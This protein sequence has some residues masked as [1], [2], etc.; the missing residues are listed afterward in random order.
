MRT[1]ISLVT[2]LDA[3]WSS[4]V[5]ARNAATYVAN[6]TDM[7]NKFSGCTRAVI[8]YVNE[9]VNHRMGSNMVLLL[10]VAA[11]DVYNWL[12]SMQ[13]I[14]VSELF[15]SVSNS[16]GEYSCRIFSHIKSVL[17]SYISSTVTSNSD[18][19]QEDAW[20][21]SVVF[22]TTIISKSP[23]GRTLTELQAFGIPITS[24][25]RNL[26]HFSLNYSTSLYPNTGDI[27]NTVFTFMKAAL[28]IAPASL[29][30]EISGILVGAVDAQVQHFQQIQSDD[31]NSYSLVKR[32]QLLL[33]LALALRPG[34][35]ATSVIHSE[36]LNVIFHL[37]RVSA[38]EMKLI[39]KS[40]TTAELLSLLFAGDL[41]F[42]SSGLSLSQ[43]TLVFSD[44]AAAK[45]PSL[46][47]VIAHPK[48][49]SKLYQQYSRLI[50]D[51]VVTAPSSSPVSLYHSD[52]LLHILSSSQHEPSRILL[53]DILSYI[54][55][56]IACNPELVNYVVYTMVPLLE[57]RVNLT[58]LSSS[59][60]L[61]LATILAQVTAITSRLCECRALRTYMLH[62]LMLTFDNP[63]DVTKVVQCLSWLPLLL[64]GCTTSSSRSLSLV[65]MQGEAAELARV[66]EGLENLVSTRFPLDS[67]QLPVSSS[68]G[69]EFL[70]ILEAYLQ[71]FQACGSVIMLPPLYPALR[72]G[73]QHIYYQSFIKVISSV[74]KSLPSL[75]PT[76]TMEHSGS[77]HLYTE[78][79]HICNFCLEVIYNVYQDVP[80]K[81]ILLEFLLLPTLLSLSSKNMVV[82]FSL[83]YH[84]GLQIR[85][86]S[87]SSDHS[88]IKV[89]HDIIAGDIFPANMS[90][91][92]LLSHVYMV[93]VAY[94]MLSL[95][96]DHCYV[97]DVKLTLTAA[98][99]HGDMSNTVNIKGSELTSAVLKVAHKFVRT[100]M[101][102]IPNYYAYSIVSELKE[103]LFELYAA[104][105]SCLV[106]IVCKTQS[107]EKFYD[108]FIFSQKPSEDIYD[109]ILHYPPLDVENDASL[110]STFTRK[111]DDARLS[112][113][114]YSQSDW[115]MRNREVNAVVTVQRLCTQAK[116]RLGKGGYA[117]Q[118]LQ[119]CMLSSSQAVQSVAAPLQTSSIKPPS[120]T[121]VEGDYTL[122]QYDYTNMLGNGGGSSATDYRI[123][124]PNSAAVVAGWDDQQ[125][126]LE[127][128]HFNSIHIM[129]TLVRA[130]QRMYVL[131]K[132]KW[133]ANTATLPN[134]LKECYELVLSSKHKKAKMFILRL[135]IN[136]PVATIIKPWL[137]LMLPGVLENIYSIYCHN[138]KGYHYLL[139]DVMFTFWD[140]WA[141]VTIPVASLKHAGM[142]L[143]FLLTHLDH[144]D[145]DVLK[146]NLN[147][148]CSIFPRWLQLYSTSQQKTRIYNIALPYVPL[149]VDAIIRLLNTAYTMTGGA[150]GSIYSTGS[151]AVRYRLAALDVVH[152]LLDCNYPLLVDYTLVNNVLSNFGNPN[153]NITTQALLQ[154]ILDNLSISRKE[155]VQSSCQVIGQILDLLNAHSMQA[156]QVLL[157]SQLGEFENKVV[158][159]IDGKDKA[160]RGKETVVYC[161][162]C[163]LANY[164]GFLKREMICR[165]L[166]WFN[167]FTFQGRYS[168]LEMLLRHNSIFVKSGTDC[169]H[170]MILEL[171]R[172]FIKPM[173]VDRNVTA[174]GRGAGMVKIPLLQVYALILLTKHIQHI[175]NTSEG[176]QDP[177]TKQHN[178]TVL[179]EVLISI[180]GKD[181][182]V[183]V[184]Y[185]INAN[186][187]VSV[188]YAA[189]NLLI[190]I[191]IYR[192]K[193]LAGSSSKDVLQS[194]VQLL[195]NGLNDPDGDIYSKTDVAGQLPKD[196]NILD[197]ISNDSIQK[198]I[199]P[200]YWS[201]RSP[202][203]QI[204]QL[205][206][207]FFQGYYLIN[208]V[209]IGQ[210]LHGYIILLCKELFDIKSVNNWL[211]Y[212]PSLL[213]SVILQHPK[214]LEVLFNISLL[215]NVTPTYQPLSTRSS[216][217]TSSAGFSSSTPLFALERTSQSIQMLALQ[218]PSIAK[219]FAGCL[220]QGLQ[221][222]I[223]GTSY[224]GEDR[225]MKYV[226]GTQQISW[227]QNS[228]SFD[229]STLNYS[230]HKF[231]EPTGTTK[232]VS[233]AASSSVAPL[234]SFPFQT[235]VGGGGISQPGTFSMGP[236]TSL[237]R[238]M[239]TQ[240]LPVR[241]SAHSMQQA[242]SSI[243]NKMIYRRT[244]TAEEAQNKHMSDVYNVDLHA[245]YRVGE[246]PD[247]A[248][249]AAN[250]I[251][252]L[253]T[254]CLY[255]PAA[256]SQL[257]CL[258]LVSQYRSVD[259]VK[260]GIELIDCLCDILKQ[261]QSCSPTCILI[262]TIL[263]VFIEL[264]SCQPEFVKVL[265]AKL[266]DATVCQIALSCGC[267]H[268]GIRYLEAKLNIIKNSTF[269]AGK[270][271]SAV[272][273]DTAK[274]TGHSAKRRKGASSSAGIGN[275][276]DTID[277]LFAQIETS[278]G[279]PA[280][281]KNTVVTFDDVD[282][283]SIFIQ[284]MHLYD[285]LSE[286]NIVNTLA[287]A[288]FLNDRSSDEAAAQMKEAI[289]YE[290]R[291]EF[292][293]AVEVYNSLLRGIGSNSGSQLTGPCKKRNFA[294]SQ[295]D[296]SSLG[297]GQVLG[298]LVGRSL[299]CYH[300]LASWESLY[301]CT[302]YLFEGSGVVDRMDLDGES[303]QR[304]LSDFVLNQSLADEDRAAHLRRTAASYY[305]RSFIHLSFP[306]LEKPLAMQSRAFLATQLIA[307]KS[308]HS[309]SLSSLDLAAS[310]IL[311]ED[312]YQASLAMKDAVS[313][314]LNK[315]TMLHAVAYKGKAGLLLSLQRMNELRDFIF[316][317]TQQ[318][319]IAS[320]ISAMQGLANSTGQQKKIALNNLEDDIIKAWTLS[321]PNIFD[322]LHHWSDVIWTRSLM[323]QKLADSNSNQDAQLSAK[324]AEHIS[325]MFLR[326]AVAAVAQG[327]LTAVKPLLETAN[328]V[329]KGMRV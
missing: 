233:G 154:A 297:Q 12:V 133:I 70:V 5:V 167:S 155:L 157:Y 113:N 243:I 318:A 143:N 309:A 314:F 91:E 35:V 251:K 244:M 153:T 323:L 271:L 94:K 208:C 92:T 119:S 14:Q 277:E 65:D 320:K 90:D 188:R 42:Y 43:E 227:T 180:I 253:Q 250:L 219:K 321:E 99:V 177:E 148:V 34:V 206:Y 187:H 20:I 274:S 146:E 231:A 96:Y 152:C 9:H 85:M 61:Q 182:T 110:F 135:F 234:S 97:G 22:L 267:F 112:N 81:R 224:T 241:F 132:E 24:L 54:S 230:Y 201:K 247:I 299:E 38:D 317:N 125:V 258:L 226:K 134:W 86:S 225:N 195:L 79:K 15:D 17:D 120:M 137:H 285:R 4:N 29:C 325:G 44:S 302:A 301:S 55:D 191:F 207:E 3:D 270:A 139:R 64:P 284:L 144:D 279:D 80:I 78:V 114:I 282:S 131:F 7:L 166:L 46:L 6:W 121:R 45:N 255:N 237:P 210:G 72:E 179:Q 205:I 174:I 28:E 328:A 263:Q 127:M 168:Y 264:S 136:Q 56:Q 140:T 245:E 67:S 200:A 88:I 33:K 19:R 21:R 82:L 213:L 118:Y 59:A 141:D 286:E 171:V 1:F 223:F 202:R 18:W 151:I 289:D 265:H 305:L 257:L 196:S 311:L 209:N 57:S 138:K 87:V 122:S 292:T 327:K 75:P 221:T 48:Y 322:P 150:H 287:E 51:A 10:F 290:A 123:A 58:T 197:S 278:T 220:S 268:I 183:A 259:L 106:T 246:A 236:P 298:L 108:N 11:L 222:S 239:T 117:S 160:K 283:S 217:L 178:E 53:E 49:G 116:K 256:S 173:L 2:I 66:Q 149:E 77:E 293:S 103:T 165:P 272:S 159:I 69:K 304:V 83:G 40:D 291:G 111:F 199:S 39:K 95:L 240:R 105:F 294:A 47:S 175:C 107:E 71:A 254:L 163:I 145:P 266:P 215:D 273:Q 198:Y 288:V 74:P 124:F 84:R 130:I 41:P 31:E 36:V 100:Q 162:K 242:Q 102:S 248:I 32:T 185:C 326:S 52:N 249:S 235:T 218:S 147:S 89:L 229:K 192:E 232:L 214:N 128:N 319:Y 8:A 329:R 211:A 204:K 310:H 228:T 68:Q 269:A 252:P 93:T 324:G 275:R 30:D 169:S 184:R 186:N 164:S 203:K 62:E 307:L 50:I 23:S 181:E 296:A 212:A 170:V 193:L 280:A 312:Y 308:N 142:I 16:N 300:K 313:T 13:I 60:I 190:S 216:R 101:S 260:E 158:D 261:C 63:K 295:L 189:Y 306:L 129:G 161:Y 156:K 172:S 176:R 194:I 316:Y 37:C 281:A 276:S 98:F 76:D 303:A 126:V 238:Y 27:Y 26:V 104:A 25:F 315:F 115:A 262:P 109:H 73:K